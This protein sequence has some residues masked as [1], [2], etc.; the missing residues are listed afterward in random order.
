MPLPAHHLTLAW[1]ADRFRAFATLG[2]HYFPDEADRG[3]FERLRRYSA[4]LAALIDDRDEAAI[5]AA[6]GRDA[7]V[8]TPMASIAWRV[9]TADGVELW[10]TRYVGDEL[11]PDLLA[12]AGKLLQAPVPERPVMLTDSR[13]LALP[14]PH[15]HVALYE[16]VSAL[17]ARDVSAAWPEPDSD[18]QKALRAGGAARPPAPED[19]GQEG[20]T[21]VSAAAGTICERIA[22]LAAEGAAASGDSYQVER[23]TQ[24]RRLAENIIIETVEYEPLSEYALNI[25]IA[26]TGAGVVFFD[27][28]RRVLLVQRSDT[29]HWGMPEGACDVGESWVAT[30]VREMREE[31]G[32]RVDPETLTLVNVFDNRAVTPEKL[33]IP[34]A[35]VFT[36]RL[37]A[38]PDDLAINHEVRQVMWVTAQELVHLDL[39]PGHRAKIGAALDTK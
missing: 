30:A 28:R 34:I 10:R 11:M 15:T 2:L 14:G 5:A 18:L 8:H 26:A 36:A 27:D 17:E 32:V 22:A 13:A 9:T 39:W 38:A 21:V 16:V 20:P 24:V 1:L 29:G 3:R 6:Y 19:G 37:D 35:A 33:S 25:D 31:I 12:D 23:F 4:E 7:G